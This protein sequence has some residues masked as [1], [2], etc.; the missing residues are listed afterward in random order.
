M[1]SGADTC[2]LPKLKTI[3]VILVLQSGTCDS[4][5]FGRL[6]RSRWR[7]ED[8]EDG[9][10]SAADGEKQRPARLQKVCLSVHKGPNSRLVCN[11]HTLLAPFAASEDEGLDILVKCC[12]PL[13]YR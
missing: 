11:H 7:A 4:E 13:N 12:L 1:L 6:V 3:G 9:G 2:L 8:Y 5:D 10:Y